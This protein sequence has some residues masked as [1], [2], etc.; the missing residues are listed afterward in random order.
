[1][2]KEFL[3]YNVVRNN[4]LKL[5]HRIY[6]DGFIPDVIYVSLRG[7][8]YLGNVIS[9]YFKIVRRGSRPVYY[10]AVVARSYTGVREADQVKIEG[11]TYDPAHLRIGD[12]VLLVDDIFDSGRTI[13]FLTEVILEKG[14][15]REDIKVAV[16]DYKYFYDKKE[17]LPV[18]PDYW[19]RKHDLSIHD[20]DRWIHYMSHELV[21]LIPDDLEEYYY[22][23][24]PELREVLAVL[25]AKS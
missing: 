6:H 11:W 7:G 5:A 1:M 12:K 4:A 3:P 2:H 19:C 17:Q 21:G 18:Q 23:Q 10:A 9:E 16:H 13:N 20:E 24:D 22:A 25:K 8:A 15:P 14:I